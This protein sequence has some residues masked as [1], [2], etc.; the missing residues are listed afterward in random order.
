MAGRDGKSPGDHTHR[1]LFDGSDKL[2][3]A[4][5]NTAV[6]KLLVRIDASNSHF[7]TIDLHLGSGPIASRHYALLVIDECTC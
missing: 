3:L 4:Q 6:E 5:T 2:F 7:S 1:R